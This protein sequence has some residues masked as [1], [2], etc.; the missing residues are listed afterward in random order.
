M[1]PDFPKL[2]SELSAK[3]TQYLRNKVDFHLGALSDISRIH[4]FE[5]RSQHIILESGGEETSDF[6]EFQ[7]EMIIDIKD[8]PDM[9]LDMVLLKIDNVAEEMAKSMAGTIYGSINKSVHEAGN[10]VVG[11]N[12]EITAQEILDVLS[13]M[14]IDFGQ[15]GKHQLQIHIH[16]S[17]SEE[18]KLAFEELENNPALKER[19][20]F[21]MEKKREE[22]RAREASRKL[23]G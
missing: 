3:L 10:V 15:D 21:I 19:H 8:I 17:R 23:V 22:Y 20:Y 11:Q 7:H 2:K 14:Q 6:K 12:K 18:F 9:T 1:L 16:P 13:K 5:G 4:L